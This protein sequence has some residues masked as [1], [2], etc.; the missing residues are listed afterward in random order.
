MTCGLPEYDPGIIFVNRFLNLFLR[1]SSLLLSHFLPSDW[2]SEIDIVPF[3]SLFP[4][5]Y[6]LTPDYAG[7][8]VFQLFWS[9]ARSFAFLRKWFWIGKSNFYRSGERRFPPAFRL[10]RVRFLA[11]SYAGMAGCPDV[12]IQFIFRPGLIDQFTMRLT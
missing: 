5:A 7:S 3:F 2:L 1:P 10:T 11:K 8:T 12:R 9:F 4:A 6:F